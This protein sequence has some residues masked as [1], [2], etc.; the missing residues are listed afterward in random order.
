MNL[1]KA[2]N[3][4]TALFVV[5]L[6]ALIVG[7]VF[8][9]KAD[10]ARAHNVEDIVIE[11][12]GDYTETEGNYCYVY[13]HFKITNNT[14]KTLNYVEVKTHF[15]DKNGRSLGTMTTTLGSIYGNGLSLEKGESVVKTTYLEDPYYSMSDLFEGL[16]ENGVSAYNVEHEITYAYWSDG[17][18]WPDND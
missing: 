5:A 15:T 18:T 2:K 11:I 1:N 9:V 7:L 16:Y 13:T 4:Q 6:I 12:T 3:I 14:R 17:Y 10:K 8:S